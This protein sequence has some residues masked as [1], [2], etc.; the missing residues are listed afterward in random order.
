MQQAGGNQYRAA[1]I[2]GLSRPT[3]RSRLRALNLSV[4]QVVVSGAGNS[5]EDM[6]YVD[7]DVSE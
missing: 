4:E 7:R 6:E 1:E 3:L 2:L 5:S